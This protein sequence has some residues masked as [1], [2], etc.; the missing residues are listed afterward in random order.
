M[1]TVIVGS[2]VCVIAVFDSILKIIFDSILYYLDSLV[3]V[4]YRVAIL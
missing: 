1:V 4:L 3:F 2:I